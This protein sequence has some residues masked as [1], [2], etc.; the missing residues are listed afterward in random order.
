L[1]TGN[2]AGACAASGATASTLATGAL[3]ASPAG[4]GSL[5]VR[6]ATGSAA[7]AAAPTEMAIRTKKVRMAGVLSKVRT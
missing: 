6:H 4:A 3:G 7:T 1:G 2:A 5:L